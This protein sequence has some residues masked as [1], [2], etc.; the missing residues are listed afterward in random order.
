MKKIAIVFFLAA[1]LAPAA[2]AQRASRPAADWIATLER[3][4]A[5][6]G[7]KYPRSSPP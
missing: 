1:V 5:S 2:G 3:P 7:S 6:V 4:S